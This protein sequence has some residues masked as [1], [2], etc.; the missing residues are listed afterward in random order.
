MIISS[1]AVLAALGACADILSHEWDIDC[2]CQDTD[3]K[4]FMEK[5]RI[6]MIH[7]LG[8]APAGYLTASDNGP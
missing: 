8:V 6:I 5:K 4:N 2:Y 3:W 1:D 7:L